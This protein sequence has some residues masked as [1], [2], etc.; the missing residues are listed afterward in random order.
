MIVIYIFVS[1]SIKSGNSGFDIWKMI[2]KI[3][4][5]VYNLIPKKYQNDISL[6][7]S[8]RTNKTIS[9]VKPSEKTN[10]AKKILL[11]SALLNIIPINTFSNHLNI[12]EH[13]C[14]NN[15]FSSEIKFSEH[16]TSIGYLLNEAEKKYVST[17]DNM[18]YF[19]NGKLNNHWNNYWYDNQFN[20]WYN[21]WFNKREVNPTINNTG[22]D[23]QIHNT[24]IISGFRKTSSESFKISSC[25]IKKCSSFK[26]KDFVEIV[27]LNL[28]IYYIFK[29]WKYIR[30]YFYIIIHK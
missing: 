3:G 20:H 8:D 5:S 9:E 27:V 18:T 30:T 11:L 25:C 4:N 14:D 7:T 17:F 21:N 12:L 6:T 22:K 28:L 1:I 24:K 29:K 13:R 26:T 19:Y 2:Y 15:D 10:A 16:K 23:H